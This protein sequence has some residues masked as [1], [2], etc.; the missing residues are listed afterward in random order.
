MQYNYD[1]NVKYYIYDLGS[2]FCLVDIKIQHKSCDNNFKKVEYIGFESYKIKF[3][4]EEEYFDQVTF[5]IIY[6]QFEDP[7]D[8]IDK[9]DV[10]YVQCAI[11]KEKLYQTEECKESRKCRKVLKFK[12]VQFRTN[13]LLKSFKKGFLAPLISDCL[14]K[15]LDK[16]EVTLL[17]LK[18]DYCLT[19]LSIPY[20]DLSF[21]DN[22][23]YSTKDLKIVGFHVE[24]DLNRMTEFGSFMID[25]GEN[26]IITKKYVSVSATIVGY[27][28]NYINIK[29]GSPLLNIFHS[30]KNKL[31]EEPVILNKEVAL[32]IGAYRTSS[33]E[34]LVLKGEVVGIYENALGIN[35]DDK[36]V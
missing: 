31:K 13:R 3:I 11:Y 34:G 4:E 22:R 20:F 12:D 24:K 2:D 16:K 6:H 29:T 10:D 21:R 35:F 27:N 28:D 17:E 14:S 1:K 5:Q 9:F 18:Q 30:F 15:E 32:L 26:E 33:S 7:M 19:N 36:F 25:V 8:L 23:F